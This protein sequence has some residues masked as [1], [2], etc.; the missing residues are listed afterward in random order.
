M[1]GILRLGGSTSS[2]CILHIQ[3]LLSFPSLEF[4]LQ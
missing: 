2:F 1:W 4:F 3:H